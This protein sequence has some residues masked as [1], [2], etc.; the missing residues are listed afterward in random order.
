MNNLDELLSSL[1]LSGPCATRQPAAALAA[2]AGLKGYGV[3]AIDL[4]GITD[5]AALMERLK[6]RSTSPSGSDVTGMRWR[7][8]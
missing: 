3:Y 6:A 7:T 5:K 1:T 2:A 8:A 4:A